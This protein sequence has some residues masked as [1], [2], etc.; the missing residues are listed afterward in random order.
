M[1]IVIK[2]PGHSDADK[3]GDVVCFSAGDSRVQQQR[4]WLTFSRW[5]LMWAGAQTGRSTGGRLSLRP[6][7]QIGRCPCHLERFGDQV[8]AA[9]AAT[10]IL[11]SFGWRN[12]S[13]IQDPPGFDFRG[14]LKVKPEFVCS[15]VETCL[16]DLEI[17]GLPRF[18]VWQSANLSNRSARGVCP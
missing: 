7:P 1:E 16:C 18:G 4:G 8:A 14:I 13:V 6:R 9:M 10:A 12:C 15:S 2:E 3:R 17:R 5:T 11:Q